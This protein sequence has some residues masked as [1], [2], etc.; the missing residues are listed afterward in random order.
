MY[1]RKEAAEGLGIGVDLLDRIAREFN[2]HVSGRAHI[3]EAE[4][5]ILVP[6]VRL[7]HI[8][9]QSHQQVVEALKVLQS[10][11]LVAAHEVESIDGDPSV[12][13]AVE[14]PNKVRAPNVESVSPRQ[15]N[16]RLRSGGSRRTRRE[17]AA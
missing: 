10:S 6:I 5:E 8:L 16:H 12:V 9:G 11:G 1:T 2:G 13:E 15:R 7:R 17:R 4:L 14:L 3:R